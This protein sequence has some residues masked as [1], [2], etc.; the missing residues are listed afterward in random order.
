[1]TFIVG[2]RGCWG[3]WLLVIGYWLLVIGDLGRW[4]G[5][6]G[7]G[8]AVGVESG[9]SGVPIVKDTGEGRTFARLAASV[10]ILGGGTNFKKKKKGRGR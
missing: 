3:Y 9:A 7:L 1:M 5:L 4:G 8:G 10:E 2:K 6:W